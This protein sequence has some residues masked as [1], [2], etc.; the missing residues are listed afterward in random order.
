MSQSKI[1]NLKSNIPSLA[2]LLLLLLGLGLRLYDLIDQPIDFHPTR[3]LRGAIVARGMYYEMQPE[4]DP[5]IRQKAI[6]YWAS[7]GEYEPP[8]LER[9]VA[10]TYLVVGGEYPWIARIYNSLMWIIGGAALFALARCAT[11][12]ALSALVALAYYLILPFSVQASRSFQPDP[13]MVMWLVLFAYAIYRWSEEWRSAPAKLSAPSWKWSILAGI[14]GGLSVL[15]K[16]IAAYTIA[17]TAVSLVLYTVIHEQRQETQGTATRLPAILRLPLNILRSPQ[18]WAMALFMVIPSGLFYLTQGARASQYFTSWTLALSHLLLESWLYLR[19]INLVQELTGWLPLLLGLLGIILAKPRLRALLIGL[20]L[21]YIG[22]GLFLPYQMY[23]HNYYHLQVIPILALSLAPTVQTILGLLTRLNEKLVTAAAKNS[24]LPPKAS[25]APQI[26]LALLAAAGLVYYSWLALVPLRARDYRDE[27]VLW[28]TVA[29]YLPNDGK[30]IA[31]TQDYGYRL[32]YYGWRK[33]ILWP[34][35]GEQK[36]SELR[37]S[38]KEF[39]TYFAK[40]TQNINYFLITSFRQFDDQPDLKA[41]LETHYPI[42][43]QG[44]G[45]LIYD[46]SSPK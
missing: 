27:P 29:S 17:V 24:A 46:L 13:G 1:S 14:F 7:T 32:M 8:F 10:L 4:A 39:E 36:L 6:N 19:W 16:A 35:R 42:Q 21:G 11:G 30:I 18:I 2:A 12:S 31:L 45:Y 38:E 37:G 44:T 43:A 25:V 3:Q 9:A 20:W 40:Q 28:Q 22:Y 23:T 5:E 33:V 26:M 15:T 41:Y 34:N